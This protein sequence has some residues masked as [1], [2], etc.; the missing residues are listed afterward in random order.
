MVM[1]ANVPR[2]LSA[3]KWYCQV[4]WGIVNTTY[5]LDGKKL[6]FRCRTV[7]ATSGIT[8]TKPQAFGG[9]VCETGNG[10]RYCKER[11]QGSSTHGRGPLRQRMNPTVGF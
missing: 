6:K 5:S 11:T 4:G 8:L 1:V 7:D 9:E 3:L 2:A 10:E